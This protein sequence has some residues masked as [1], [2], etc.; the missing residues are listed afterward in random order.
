[1]LSL[2]HYAMFD[3]TAPSSLHY[4]NAQLFIIGTVSVDPL[5]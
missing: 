1:M 4:V 2:L 5:F 3:S